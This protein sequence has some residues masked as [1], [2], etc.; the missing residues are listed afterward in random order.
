M[1]KDIVRAFLAILLF[2]ISTHAKTLYVASHSG[3]KLFAFN[4]NGSQLEYLNTCEFDRKGMGPTDIDI[5]HEARVIFICNERTN[6]FNLINSRT[7]DDLGTIQAVGLLDGTGIA[8]DAVRSRLYATERDQGI[9]HVY[10]WDADTLTLTPT[11]FSPVILA[12]IDYACDPVIVGN[13]LYVSKFLYSRINIPN[14]TQYKEVFEYNIDNNFAYVATHDMG[15]SNDNTDNDVV[16]IA[17][18]DY[19]NANNLYGVAYKDSSK[20]IKYDIDTPTNSTYRYIESKLVSAVA[21][22]DTGLLYTTNVTGY[23]FSIEVWDASDWLITPNTPTN[24]LASIS[25][26]TVAMPTEY[27]LAD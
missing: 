8:Y 22:S 13:K 10:D 24:L 16:S 2:S 25:P 26:M 1:K 21:D 18:S 27:L 14:R 6:V 4:I 17:Y 15:I 23:A 19:G 5:D 20:I 12:N 7:L 9:M 3:S 11:A